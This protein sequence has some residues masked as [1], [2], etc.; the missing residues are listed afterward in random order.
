MKLVNFSLRHFAQWL[1]F[2]LLTLLVALSLSW[3]LLATVDFGYAWLHD[4]T[5]IAGHI[6]EYAPKNF[7]K[8]DFAVTD[9]TERARL[10]HGIVEAIHHQGQGL[11]ELTYHDP[12]GRAITTLFTAAEVTHLQDVAHLIDKITFAAAFM[13]PLW[14]VVFVLSLYYRQA[15]P[16]IKQLAGYVL[17]FALLTTAVLSLGA[18]EVFYQLHI[19]IFPADHPWFFYYEESL[20]STMMQAPL[21]FG[22]IAIMLLG[23]AVVI[24]VLLLTF[25]HYLAQR[26]TQYS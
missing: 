21:L 19:W 6:A 10:F 13:L 26:R 4:H 3:V 25:Y 12:Q 9:T 11:A 16:S 22:Y 18:T 23:L 1:S 14:V 2:L 17:L 5:S 7:N 15:L 8:P 20:M 24:T